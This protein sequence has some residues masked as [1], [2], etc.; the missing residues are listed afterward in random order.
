VKGKNP[1]RLLLP[2]RA[3]SSLHIEREFANRQEV[4]NSAFGTAV[5]YQERWT[6]QGLRRCNTQRNSRRGLQ[7]D[8]PGQRH[9][10]EES[11]LKPTC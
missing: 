3:V 8:D 10:G 1:S 4:Q 9:R 11:S 2:C 6:A 7:S 5:Q